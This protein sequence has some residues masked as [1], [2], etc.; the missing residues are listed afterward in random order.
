MGIRNNS[1]YRSPIILQI[2][3]WQDKKNSANPAE[4]EKTLEKIIRELKK[5]LEY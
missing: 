4:T 3:K 1:N 5:T 2:T